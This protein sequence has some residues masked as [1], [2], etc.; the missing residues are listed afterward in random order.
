MY[1]CT[2]LFPFRKHLQYKPI[3]RNIMLIT[4]TG[5]PIVKNILTFKGDQK[6]GRNVQS[7]LK[8]HLS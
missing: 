4:A 6:L 8:C 3:D 1:L 2:Q 5:V 7:L